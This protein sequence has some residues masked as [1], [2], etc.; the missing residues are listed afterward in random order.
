MLTQLASL[1]VGSIRTGYTA[2]ASFTTT[3]SV[4][5]VG[6]DVRRLFFNI[7]AKQVRRIETRHLVSYWTDLNPGRQLFARGIRDPQAAVSNLPPGI[8][9]H[10][11]RAIRSRFNLRAGYGQFHHQLTGRRTEQALA[12][13]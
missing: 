6:A 10:Q 11:P 9:Q 5:L 8:R 12:P 2:S 7:I 13:R 4:P 1:N 3:A